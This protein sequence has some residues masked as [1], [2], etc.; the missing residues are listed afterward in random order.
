MAAARRRQHLF[1]RRARR[2][3][4]DQDAPFSRHFFGHFPGVIKMAESDVHVRRQAVF[5]PKR[6]ARHED[7]A[8]LHDGKRQEPFEFLEM[9]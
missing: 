4:A 5:L 2:E 8:R 1:L 7:L 9:S 3:R 6:R